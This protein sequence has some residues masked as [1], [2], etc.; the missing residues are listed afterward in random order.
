[1]M[2]MGII[3]PLLSRYWAEN[4]QVEFKGM[5]QKA[6]NTL[7]IITL[8]LVIGTLFLAKP[9]ML[10]I[11]GQDF[12]ISGDILKIIML[13][14]S[15]VFMGSIFAH[16]IVAINRQKLMI[17]AY[18]ATAIL[19]LIGYLIFIP[20]YSYYGAAW[21]TVFSEVMIAV[22]SFLVVWR[23]TKVLPRWNIFNKCLLAS[24]IMGLVL[25]LLAGLNVWLLCVAALVVYWVVMYLIKG[26]SKELIK[27]VMGI[28]HPE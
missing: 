18:L 28:K 19:S 5:L 1:M 25:W 8:P 21:V 12:I 10:L 26:I 2:F 13:A 4:N 27:E 7:S 23:F 15:F 3:L 11:A 14:C 9:V 22:I 24:L 16:T 17:W 20:K 6:F